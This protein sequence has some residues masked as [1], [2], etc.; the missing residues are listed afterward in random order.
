[1]KKPL[2]QH[3]SGG[4]LFKNLLSFGQ[5]ALIFLCVPMLVGLFLHS[6]ELSHV[7]DRL[8][9]NQG[10]KITPE[11][12]RA[13]DAVRLS[14]IF[15]WVGVLS[16]ICLSVALFIALHRAKAAAQVAA[17]QDEENERL[18]QAIRNLRDQLSSR[19]KPQSAEDHTN[20]V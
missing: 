11:T 15:V 18:W 5:L 2:S 16:T 9:E 20:P 19:E 14:Q 7:V 13:E 3:Y 8:T 4:L 12:R 1:M 6:V 17:L 10:L